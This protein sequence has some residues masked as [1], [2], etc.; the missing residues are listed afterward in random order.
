M[1]EDFSNVQLS[2]ETLDCKP[3]L[4]S[5]TKSN[6]KNMESM[7]ISNKIFVDNPISLCRLEFLREGYA[8][9]A[10]HS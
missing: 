6:P 5:S 4:P 2:S 3:Q 8:N 10:T 7:N 9:I 1:K